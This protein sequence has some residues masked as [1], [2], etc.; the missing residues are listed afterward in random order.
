MRVG[1]RGEGFIPVPDNSRMPREST[2]GYFGGL[3]A[4]PSAAPAFVDNGAGFPTWAA[5]SG[6]QRRTQQEDAAGPIS[7]GVSIDLPLE[8]VA[9]FCPGEVDVQTQNPIHPTAQRAKGYSG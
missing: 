2:P 6:T 5:R 4:G 7:F 3:A 9:A 8:M 1:W